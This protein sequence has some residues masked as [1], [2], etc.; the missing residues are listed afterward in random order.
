MTFLTGG[1]TLGV[2]MSGFEDGKFGRLF[3]KQE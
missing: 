3:L 2:E 1:A